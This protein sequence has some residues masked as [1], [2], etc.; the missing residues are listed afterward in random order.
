MCSRV[1]HG[2]FKFQGALHPTALRTHT[3]ARCTDTYKHAESV[4]NHAPTCHGRP[5]LPD[6]LGIPTQ[7]LPAPAAQ[8]FDPRP[9]F[10][11]IEGSQ[12]Q[13]LPAPAQPT[14]LRNPD[15]PLASTQRV[16]QQLGLSAPD[17]VR[18][19]LEFPPQAHEHLPHARPEVPF[20]TGSSP[21]RSRPGRLARHLC[22]GSRHVWNE[23][24]DG[25]R[26]GCGRR[27]LGSA[28]RMRAAALGGVFAAVPVSALRAVLVSAP[29][30]VL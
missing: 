22:R 25:H 4:A 13:T 14:W 16:R 26:Q 10:L 2:S 23:Q 19:Q 24:R 5:C 11:S 30:A 20:I 9:G 7:A 21:R 8:V 28:W 15:A 18:Q 1:L 29:P 6:R 17:R 12:R 3:P 27:G